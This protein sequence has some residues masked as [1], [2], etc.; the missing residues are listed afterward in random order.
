MPATATITA[1]NT[2]VA[3]TKAVATQVNTNFSNFRGTLVPIETDTAA[4]SDL[5][6]DLGSD[7][8]RWRTAYVRELDIET[9]TG[10]ATILLKGNTSAT[11][12]SLDILIEGATIGTFAPGGYKGTYA[13]FTIP[14]VALDAYVTLKTQTFTA[15]GSWTCPTGVEAAWVQ[16]QGAGGS[17]GGSAGANGGANGGGGGGGGSS[18][19]LV[20]KQILVSGG[21]VYSMTV[22][23]GPSGGAGGGGSTD[24]NIGN[25]GAASSVVLSGSTLCAARGG[26]PGGPGLSASG[27]GGA[28][29]VASTPTMIAGGAGGN[30]TVGGSAGGN[31]DDPNF[32]GGSGGASAGSGGG[33]GGSGASLFGAGVIGGAGG[34][35]A[36]IG[37][38][39]ST[40]TKGSGG[41]GAG[42]GG[43]TNNSGNSGGTAGDGYIQIMWA[44]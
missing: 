5:T 34:A 13:N 15:S 12:G 38:G 2:F 6:H 22:G 25:T 7:S 21:N 33:G 29:G 4:A 41:S 14:R 40:G 16:V 20:Q 19:A 9:S 10:T 32:S 35:S 3:N 44:E 36:S 42:G 27:A 24:G 31:S 39:G 8:H 30:A 37:I 28:G 1:F 17:G 26:N 18:G 11:L 23:T 43:V